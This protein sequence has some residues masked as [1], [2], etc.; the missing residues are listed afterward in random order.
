MERNGDFTGRFH[1]EQYDSATEKSGGCC[2]R[3]KKWRVHNQEKTQ[4][5]DKELK[6]PEGQH[7][8]GGDVLVTLQVIFR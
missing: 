4:V 6:E 2:K 5:W 8:P 1:T 7:S 3:S